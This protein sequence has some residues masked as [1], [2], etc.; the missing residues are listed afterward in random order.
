M[1]A[2]F[3]DSVLSQS[4][5]FTRIPAPIVNLR[6]LV[7]SISLE[8]WGLERGHE[9]EGGVLNSLRSAYFPANFEQRRGQNQLIG[10]RNS[11]TR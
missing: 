9:K 8:G 3:F 5:A 7:G 11:G 2:A 6:F 4:A 10:S 1:S